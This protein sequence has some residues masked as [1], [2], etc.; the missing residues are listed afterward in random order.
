MVDELH[1]FK[2]LLY[3]TGNS[4]YIRFKI[5]KDG[6][7][8]ETAATSITSSSAS[9]WNKLYYTNRDA[10]ASGYRYLRVEVYGGT[11]NGSPQLCRMEL[12][13][14]NISTIGE[15]AL[16][17]EMNVHVVNNKL[18]TVETSNTEG[19]V[20]LYNLSGIAQS[21]STEK[22]NYTLSRK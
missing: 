20:R 5:S 21:I 9:G 3:R 14:Q 17:N 8:Y 18:I 7:I 13:T 22:K 1:D 16:V 19:E 2:L 15:A 6:V 12:N 11:T 4:D 10:I